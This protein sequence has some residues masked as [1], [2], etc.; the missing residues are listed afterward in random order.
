MQ[1]DFL[2]IKGIQTFYQDS[3]AFNTVDEQAYSNEKIM[4]GYSATPGLNT[5]LPS[6]IKYHRAGQGESH[7]QSPA[8]LLLA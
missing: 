7:L 4:V 3:S 2:L 6:M 8:D 1:S 5:G